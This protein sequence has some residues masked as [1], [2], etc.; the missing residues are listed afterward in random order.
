MAYLLELTEAKAER[1]AHDLSAFVGKLC[2]KPLCW[3]SYHDFITDDSP[4]P[5]EF[6]VIVDTDTYPSIVNDYLGFVCS[7]A[8]CK[9]YSYNGINVPLT[10]EYYFGGIENGTLVR[11]IKCLPLGIDRMPF[12]RI[13][14]S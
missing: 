1:I 9:A 10:I 12:I 8:I 11:R 14:K 2:E 13:S 3:T 6:R 7:N 5:D 4:F